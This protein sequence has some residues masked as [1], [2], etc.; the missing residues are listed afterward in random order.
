MNGI[1]K[2]SRINTENRT[3][4]LWIDSPVRYHLDYRIAM[5]ADITVLY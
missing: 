5:F 4:V 2:I 3:R 1:S